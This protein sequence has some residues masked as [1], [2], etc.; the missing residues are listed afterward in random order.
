MN[1]STHIIFLI[2]SANAAH[3]SQTF[4]IKRLSNFYNVYFKFP[5]TFNYMFG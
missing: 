3:A 1:I 2:F 5:Q 4:A